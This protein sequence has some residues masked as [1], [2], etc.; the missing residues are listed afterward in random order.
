M[1][2][3]QSSRIGRRGPRRD[4]FT[5][6]ELLVVI[7]IIGVLIALLLPAVQAARE[8]ARKATLAE[9]P[10]LQLVAQSTLEL[11]DRLEAIYTSQKAILEPV[12]EEG[13]ELELPAVQRNLAQL[14]E[15]QQDLDG[16]LTDLTQIYPRLS[17][18]DKALAR[19][20]RY[21]L[22]QLWVH[23]KRDIHLKS[24]LLEPAAEP[25]GG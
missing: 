3:F 5:L 20:L 12:A 16:L 11:T 23:N 14:L 17:E 15:A 21:E 2:H 24:F 9:S 22:R 4:G 6:I 8:A 19:P 25:R 13:G 10:E 7:A 1:L 18:Q